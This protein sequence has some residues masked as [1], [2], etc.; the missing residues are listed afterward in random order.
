MQRREL[1]RVGLGA[2]FAMACG[3]L[4]ASARG[5]LVPVEAERLKGGIT[6]VPV[7]VLKDLR[8]ALRGILLLPGDTGYDD[9]R[10]LVNRFD[11]RPAFI[12]RAAGANDV[13]RAVE[14]ARDNA[15]LI[16]VKG[17]GHSDWGVSARDRAMMLDLSLMQGVRVDP[18]KRR[19]WAAGATLS[20]R[21]DNA[22]VPHGLAVP[23]G[24]MPT[25]GVGGLATGGGIGRLSRRFGLTLDCIRS[26]DLV[27][28]AGRLV[29]ASVDEEPDLFWAVRGGGGNFGVVTG[30]EFDLH[31]IPPRV[32][33][34]SLRFPFAQAQQVLTGYGT[35]LAA[36]PDELYIDCFIGIRGT[37]E[38]SILQLGVCYSGDAAEAD[39]F[40]A[41]LRKLGTVLGD[42]IGEVD[43]LTVQGAK[44]RHSARRA[45]D[46]RSAP[47][48]RSGF[49]Q[50]FTRGLAWSIVQNAVHDAGRNVNIAFLHMGGAIARVKSDATAFSTRSATH[51]M[52]FVCSPKST[53]DAEDHINYGAQFWESLRP[54]SRGFYVNDM[55][56]GVTPEAVAADYGPNFPRLATLKAR[57][58]PTDLFRLNANIRPELA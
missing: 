7:A 52:L 45:D 20:G 56:G 46:S 21:I 22:T 17:G 10:Q 44:S 18:G 14:F 3:P 55:A 42:E 51:D 33:A 31:P 39:T 47:F 13:C 15:L 53:D 54:H 43:Y 19:A 2:T 41:P 49:G 40:V 35:I 26:V 48:F 50:G 5:S 11:R 27:T 4:G 28:A 30:F 58:D 24:G 8:D 57:Y 1:L 6:D 16:S 29:H 9:A 32:I 23:L 34:G 36:A 37:P 25:V 12:V 38:D